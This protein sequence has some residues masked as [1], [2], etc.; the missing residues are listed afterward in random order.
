MKG[1]AAKK[2]DRKA[3]AQQVNIKVEVLAT[4]EN[5]KALATPQNKKLLNTIKR[6]LGII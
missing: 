4:F 6:K 2:M 3:L 5:N 1:R